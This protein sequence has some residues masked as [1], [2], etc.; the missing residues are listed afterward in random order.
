MDR[1]DAIFF[2]LD[3]TLTDPKVG[4]TRCIQ[5][6][7]T[8]L[9]VTPPDADALTW[10][11]G[12]PLLDSFKVMLGNEAS[13]ATALTHYR[14]RFAE[15]GLYENHLYDGVPEALHRLSGRGASLFVA[16]SKPQVYAERI[17]E[18]F[19]LTMFFEGVFG[20]M[21]HGGRTSKT[22][23]LGRAL[24]ETGVK[25]HAAIMVGDRSHDMVAATV[26]GTCAVG[27]LYGFGSREE[28]AG[29]GAQLLVSSPTELSGI[30][31]G[32]R[33]AGRC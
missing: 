31:E 23:L 33:L 12:P 18:H 17:V 6:A 13:A 16:T 26:N 21:L 19:G 5:C 2:D 24:D 4:I 8:E 32:E 30:L 15:V 29:S 3:G 27:V 20:P 28:L 10:C 22:D 11:I 14:A 1:I 9:G 25:A 7:L